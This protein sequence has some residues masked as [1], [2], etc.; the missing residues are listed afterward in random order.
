MSLTAFLRTSTT[1][2]LLNISSSLKFDKLQFQSSFLNAGEHILLWYLT[3]S[4]WSSDEL[5][6]SVSSLFQ[7]AAVSAGY[8]RDTGG[9]I[10]AHKP[11]LKLHHTDTQ[12]YW[13]TGLKPNDPR[14]CGHLMSKS[15]HIL[16][17][18]VQFSPDDTPLLK[19][20]LSE[21]SIC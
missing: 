4:R 11:P 15:S 14:H 8:R 18:S 21:I 7:M 12:P 1:V 10:T 13:N 19:H 5:L 17:Q 2:K 20:V 16:I 3:L 9:V 6:L